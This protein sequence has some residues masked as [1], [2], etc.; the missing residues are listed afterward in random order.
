MGETSAASWKPFDYGVGAMIVLVVSV[1][2]AAIVYSLALLS[3]DLLN[4]PAWIF[5]PLGVYTLAYSSIAGKESTYFSVWGVVMV[6]VAV[7]FGFYDKVNAIVILGILA[8]L[9]AIIGIISYQ[10]NRK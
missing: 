10:R 2:V 1:G 9:I 8:I 5:G 3:L 7:I 6:A 4:I